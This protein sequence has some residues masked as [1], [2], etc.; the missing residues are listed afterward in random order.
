[1]SEPAEHYY[2]QY[3]ER[4]RQLRKR[5]G[6]TAAELARRLGIEG[7]TYRQYEY[8]SPL[9]QHLIARFA[10]LVQCDIAHLITGDRRRVPQTLRPGLRR[11]VAS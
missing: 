2:R 8:R 9:P 6:Y 11:R 3:I 4:T 1:M 5:A 10:R 7:A